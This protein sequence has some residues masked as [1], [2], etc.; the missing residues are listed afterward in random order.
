MNFNLK[1]RVNIISIYG[2]VIYWVRFF[3]I[4][5]VLVDFCFRFKM[6]NKLVLIMIICEL[7]NEIFFR[8]VWFDFWGI[9]FIRYFYVFIIVVKYV[10]D[11]DV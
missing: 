11:K 5:I 8:S 9:L 2:V 4:C 1:C 10:Y 6:N 7:G 3:L